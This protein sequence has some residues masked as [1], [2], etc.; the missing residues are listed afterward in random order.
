MAVLVAR[1]RTDEGREAVR[2]ATE[3]AE[4]RGEELIVFDL[5]GSGG[6]LP[7]A[8]VP[9]RSLTMRERERDAVG[10]LLDAAQHGDVSVL[11]IGMRHRSAVGK[12]LLGS[13]AQQILL[14]SAVPVLAV[15]P[16]RSD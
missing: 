15:K 8:G 10:S 16:P 5:D 1:S 14:Q 13:D 12:F 9:V 6:D 3:E 2:Y 7:D 4:R 11:V